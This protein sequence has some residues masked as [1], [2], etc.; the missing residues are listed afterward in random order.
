MHRVKHYF[1]RI[2][3]NREEENRYERIGGESLVAERS[4]RVDATSGNGRL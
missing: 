1:E 3:N 4:E 2:L